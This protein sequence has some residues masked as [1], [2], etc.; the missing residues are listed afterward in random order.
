MKRRVIAYHQDEILDWVADL[1]CGHKQH[2][3]H[4]PPWMDR[5]WVMT[6]EGR[7]KFIGST[8]NCK[9]CDEKE[10]GTE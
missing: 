5:P 2:V 3:R 1:D 9:A 8:L 7:E 10:S 6:P 4:N